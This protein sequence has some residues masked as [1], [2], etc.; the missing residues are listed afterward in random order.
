MKR[1]P[2]AS[3][4]LGTMLAIVMFAHAEAPAG[5]NGNAAHIA[6]AKLIAEAKTPQDLTKAIQD[7]LNTSIA[8]GGTKEEVNARVANV[9]GSLLGLA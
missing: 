5:S 4:I 7:V 8:K 6:M 3:L 2:A 1:T 9:V